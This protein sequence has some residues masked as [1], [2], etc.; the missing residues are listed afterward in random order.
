MQVGV[1]IS[2]RNDFY[3]NYRLQLYLVRLIKNYC[4]KTSINLNVTTFVL[5]KYHPTSKIFGKSILCI[6]Y[7]IKIGYGC[8]NTL[9]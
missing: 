6:K 7:S 3:V 1:M 2:I 4:Q 5:F 8:L 9:T